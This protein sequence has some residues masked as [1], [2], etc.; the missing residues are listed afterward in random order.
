MGM[1]TKVTFAPGTI[2]AYPAVRGLLVEQGYPI[3]VRMIEGELA[4][5]DEEPPASWRELRLAGAGNMVTLRRTDS[6]IA[7][8]VWGNADAGMLEA[9]DRMMWAF[10][11]LADGR[12]ETDEGAFTPDEFRAKFPG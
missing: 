8:V 5:P 3:E 9:R 1:E 12:I 7:F 6:A 4:F 2:P 10:A 11:Q